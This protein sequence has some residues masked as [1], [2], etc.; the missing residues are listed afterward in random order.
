MQIKVNRIL[1]CSLSLIMVTINRQ[2]PA[3]NAVNVVRSFLLKNMR[4]L[5]RGR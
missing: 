2:Y 4:P 5:N 1:R 3:L